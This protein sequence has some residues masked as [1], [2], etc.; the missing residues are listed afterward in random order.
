MQYFKTGSG[1]RLTNDQKSQSPICVLVIHVLKHVRRLQGI[2][3]K[4]DYCT[5]MTDCVRPHSPGGF[6]ADLSK[7]HHYKSSSYTSQLFV[8]L[9]E[10][11][12]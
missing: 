12:F 8:Y 2:T 3:I 6:Q 4:H 9:W 10:L 7:S 11:S 1:V 5:T